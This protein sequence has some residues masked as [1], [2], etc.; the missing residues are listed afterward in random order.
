MEEKNKDSSRGRL[1]QAAFWVTLT[2]GLLAAFL[3]T[4]LIIQ[5]DKTRPFLVN[6]MG[7]FWLVGG[8]MS[9]RWSAS[10]RKARRLSLL[11]GVIGV[12]GGILVLTREFAKGII[13]EAT[14][15]YVLGGIIVLTGLIHTVG[16]FR[17][18]EE[19]GRQRSWTSLLLGVFE[20]I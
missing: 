20:I 17:V 2:R 19:V 14:V 1:R 6:F 13:A 5:P 15:I 11:A 3:G 16:G 12:L 7:M 18:G 4:A 10:G 8:I 9:L